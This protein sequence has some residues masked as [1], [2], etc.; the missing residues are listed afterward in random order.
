MGNV[1]RDAQQTIGTASVLVN[2]QQEA[3]ARKA[4]SI[5]NTSTGGQKVSLAWGKAAVSGAGIVL[6]PGGSWSESEDGTFN[7]SNMEVWACADIAAAT[8][9]IHERVTTRDK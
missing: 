7:P 3:G 1:I 4:L 6:Y 8:I 9:S 2:V 5:I